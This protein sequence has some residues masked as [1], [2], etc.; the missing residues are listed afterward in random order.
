M[1][2]FDEYVTKF[3]QLHAARAV[4][5]SEDSSETLVTEMDTLWAQLSNRERYLANELAASNGWVYVDSLH[6]DE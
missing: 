6:H 1:A 2:A 5:T 4:A 3:A